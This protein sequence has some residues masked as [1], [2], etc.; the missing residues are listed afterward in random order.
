VRHRVCAP[1]HP[2]ST[3]ATPTFA[4]PRRGPDLCDGDP[5]R[6]RYALA[7]IRVHLRDPFGD[8][9]QQTCVGVEVGARSLQRNQLHR[10]TNVLETV[11]AHRGAGAE[12]SVLDTRR[13]SPAATIK[14][15]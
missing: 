10:G 14:P 5:F 4:E 11:L 9:D 8:R 6:G 12:E 13:R 1:A 3:A 7:G 15:A 2:D